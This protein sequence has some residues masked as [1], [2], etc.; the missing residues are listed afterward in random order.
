MFGNAPMA[1]SGISP[2]PAMPVSVSVPQSPSVPPASM[3]Q[4]NPAPFEQN[5]LGAIMKSILDPKSM[6]KELAAAGIGP[7]DIKAQIQGKD[8][9]SSLIQPTSTPPADKPKP[10][11]FSQ[12]ASDLMQPVGQS[13]H[14]IDPGTPPVGAVQQP[15]T[16]TINSL[17]RPDVVPQNANHATG[18][19]ARPFSLQQVI[20][21]LMQPVGKA[22]MANANATPGAGIPVP[23]LDAQL[24]VV[25]P[26]VGAAGQASPGA[27]LP[28]SPPVVPPA[29]S[30]TTP[31]PPEIGKGWTLE[32]N[33]PVALQDRPTN[34]GARERII[35]GLSPDIS[36]YLDE[37]GAKYGLDPNY[38]KTQAMIESGGNPNAH[39]ASG[40]DGL[41]Q[42]VPSTAKQ[43]GIAG[44]TRDWK[45]SSDA[46]ARLAVDN[47]QYLQKSLGREPTYGELYLAHQQGAGGAV[48]LLTNPK[49]KASDLVGANAV[50]QNGGSADMTAEEFSRLWTD[51]YNNFGGVS[52]DGAAAVAGAGGAN[53]E[54]GGTATEAGAGTGGASGLTD[55]GSGGQD[56]DMNLPDA[57]SPIGPR[58]G[59]YAPDANVQ[60]LMLMLLTGLSGGGA[61]IPTLTQLMNG[62]RKAA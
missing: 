36:K 50:T 61:D 6:A 9:V 47:K 22:P 53:T 31:T 62:Q 35:K 1:G 45:A 42:F 20:S 17:I 44:K 56:A 38:L 37:V 59:Q 26:V 51:K 18:A 52:G 41:F 49:A 33:T 21:D 15:N 28:I 60:K 2:Q 4:G 10:F 39:N 27:N 32:A 8:K 46:A 55:P 24:P 14:V 30:V 16:N 57:P 48:K 7:E 54:A 58:P 29:R 12:V 43:Y 19:P 34:A 11:S 5:P 23:P 13:Q 25:P 40:A 3:N